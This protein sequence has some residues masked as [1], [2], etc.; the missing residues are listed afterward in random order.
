MSSKGEETDLR[1]QKGIKSN[2]RATLEICSVHEDEIDHVRH[3]GFKGA[4]PYPL[5]AI[6]LISGF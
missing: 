5:D 2:F 6:V 1:D 4:G 3:E